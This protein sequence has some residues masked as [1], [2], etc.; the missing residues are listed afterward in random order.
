VAVV[1]AI[2][3]HELHKHYGVTRAVDGLSFRVA[4]G[5]VFALLG[6]NGAGKTTTVEILE[7]HR[8]RTS[9]QVEV[10]GFDPQTGGREYRERIG[11]VLQEAG[12]DEDFSPRELVSLYRG[13]YPRRLPA[14]EVIDLVGLADKADAKVKTLSGGQRRRL[15]LALGL[16]GDPELLF[17]DEPTTGFDPSARRKAWELVENL[18]ALGKTVLLTTHYMDEAEH[19]ADRVGVVVAGRLVALGT[20]AELGQARASATIT[21]RLPGDVAVAE[22][23]DLGAVLRPQGGDWQLRTAEPMVVLERLIGWSHSRNIALTGLT[24]ERPSLEDVYLELIEAAG[25]TGAAPERVAVT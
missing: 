20:P 12:V 23:P 25:V 21:F 10:L 8:R 9:G 5:E 15:D 14:D 19:L 24:V 7:G 11:I 17:L 18:R 3:V 22:V 4:P 16:V 2:E 6:P 1:D 13:M